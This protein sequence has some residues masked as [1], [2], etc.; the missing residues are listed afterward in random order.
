MAIIEDTGD[1][2][3]KQVGWQTDADHIL[4]LTESQAEA[5]LNYDRAVAPTK[6]GEKVVIEVIPD[7]P[8]CNPV[9]I[10]EVN[11]DD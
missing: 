5:V 8:A 10:R 2:V 3:L 7:D 9:E 1:Q 4:R 11:D 6:N